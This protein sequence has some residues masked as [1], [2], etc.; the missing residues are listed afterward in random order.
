M[1]TTLLLTFATMLVLVLLKLAFGCVQAYC[2]DELATC[3]G[4]VV[5]VFSVI[6]FLLWV[7]NGELLKCHFT[8]SL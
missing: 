6:R 3:V 4:V 7:S 1:I 2:S 5:L 8:T